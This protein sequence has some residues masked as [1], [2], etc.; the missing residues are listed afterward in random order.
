MGVRW[1][2]TQKMTTPVR[3]GHFRAGCGVLAAGTV[4]G[5]CADESASRSGAMKWNL[6]GATC[7]CAVRE[8][9]A[10][11]RGSGCGHVLQVAG[12][13]LRGWSP[14]VY[15]HTWEMGSYLIDVFAFEPHADPVRRGFQLVRDGGSGS[16]RRE[17]RMLQV[18][19][20]KIIKLAAC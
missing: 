2:R 5:A 18:P 14:T 16:R 3:C 20:D 4:R 7:G 13:K 9:G 15:I 1:L 17:N 6:M 12:W 11:G 10:G 8:L 19:G